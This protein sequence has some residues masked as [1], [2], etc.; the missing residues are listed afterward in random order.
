MKA[1]IILV[2]VGV[3]GLIIGIMSKE[4]ILC[5]GAG[6]VLVGGGLRIKGIRGRKGVEQ[7]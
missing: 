5:A 4:P 6:V 2:V 7:G 3:G 1:G